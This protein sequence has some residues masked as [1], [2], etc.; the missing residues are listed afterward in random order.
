MQAGASPALFGAL[1]FFWET[2]FRLDYFRQSNLPI[3]T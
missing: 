2:N 1:T 3:L